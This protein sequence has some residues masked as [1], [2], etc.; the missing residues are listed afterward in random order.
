M[1]S[2]RSLMFSL[3][4]IVVQQFSFR[5]IY[6]LKTWFVIH[7]SCFCL[8]NSVILLFYSEVWPSWTSIRPTKCYPTQRVHSSSSFFEPKYLFSW[9]YHECLYIR[10]GLLNIRMQ[11]HLY[12]P[13]QNYYQEIHNAKPSK[14]LYQLTCT[15]VSM[16]EKS[17]PYR[18]PTH[19]PLL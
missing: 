15:F 6:R 2:I 4:H 16:Q 12:W 18:F 3:L 10:I 9:A 7:L 14:L 13:S 17:S 19:V 11:S 5:V 8:Y 1:F